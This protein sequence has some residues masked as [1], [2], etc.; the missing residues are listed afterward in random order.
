MMFGRINHQFNLESDLML[1]F[2]FKHV[3]QNQNYEW[4]NPEYVLKETKNTKYQVYPDGT[5]VSN[6]PTVNEVKS[7]IT[8]RLAI[9][10]K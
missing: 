10:K 8:V 1:S 4:T 5:C 9:K 6:R 7:I 2:T 3:D